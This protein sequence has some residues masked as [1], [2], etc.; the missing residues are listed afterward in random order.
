MSEQTN[1]QTTPEFSKIVSAQHGPTAH[2]YYR[3]IS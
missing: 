1:K 2:V 3:G